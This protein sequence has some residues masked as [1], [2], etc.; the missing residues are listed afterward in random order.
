MDVSAD[1]SWGEAYIWTNVNCCVHNVIVGKLW[2]E[3]YGTMEVV[4]NQTGLKA[5]L[6]FKPAGWAGKDLHHVEG[7]IVDKKYD[8]F[9]LKRLKNLEKLLIF[10]SNFFV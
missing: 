2:M 4:N 7:F 5:V 1:A 8:F 3:Q 10:N 9:L 6:T